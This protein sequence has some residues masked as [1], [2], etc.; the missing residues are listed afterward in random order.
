ME[1]SE[2]RLAYCGSSDI[3]PARGSKTLE[4]AVDRYLVSVGPERGHQRSGRAAAVYVHVS[5]LDRLVF[6]GWAAATNGSSGLSLHTTLLAT[7]Q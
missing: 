5:S 7:A 6:V 1:L 3:S 2:L 4:S